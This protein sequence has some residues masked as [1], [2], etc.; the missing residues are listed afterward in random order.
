LRVKEKTFIGLLVVFFI[1]VVLSCDT[2]EDCQLNGKCINKSCQCYKGWT[3]SD[4]SALNFLPAT[5][6]P[7]YRQVNTSSWG[8]SVINGTD[9]LWHLYVAEMAFHCGLNTWTTNSIIRHAT[10]KFPQGP[11]SPAD[12]VLTY[13]AHNPTITQAPDGTYTLFH[14]GCGFN[15][16]HPQTNCT[17][18]TTPSFAKRKVN[19]NFQPINVKMNNT[20]SDE[21]GSS[22]LYSK[23]LYGPWNNLQ[24]LSPQV[25]N[26][27]PY[28]TD[29]PAPYIFPNGTTY[30]MYRS[31]NQNADPNVNRSLV[32]LAYADKW[33]G[34]PYTIPNYPVLTV[35]LE[36]PFLWRSEIDGNFHALFHAMETGSGTNLG[37][38]AFSSDGFNWTFSVNP[39]YT[40]FVTYQN[41]STLQFAR[42]E[43]PH[44]LFSN[45]N[46]W[47]LF[48]GV[49]QSWA[50]DYT[51]TLVQEI[52]Q[53]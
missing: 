43:R 8:G 34:I 2:D 25:P 31:W 35:Q 26:K 21:F 1:S 22:V 44:L 48:N 29:N 5:Q 40:A 11:F 53:S 33:D 7:A 39:A 49:Q 20:C 32:G 3:S 52:N 27:Y 24:V 18:G 47:F 51:Y 9:G 15:N 23:S 37:R 46:P 6:T 42:R 30:C 12:I 10:S 28:S 38:H 14:I 41:G 17:N 16:S 13:F 19:T 4:C 50:A 45:G 36:D